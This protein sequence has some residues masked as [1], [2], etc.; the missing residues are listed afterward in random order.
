MSSA[1]AAFAAGLGNQLMNVAGNA[2]NAE[3][4]M[5]KQKEYY[6]LIGSPKAQMEA[7][8]EAGINPFTAAGNIA[9]M[10]GD[11][12]VGQSLQGAPNVASDVA[13]L[14][15]SNFNKTV[16]ENTESGTNKNNADASLSDSQTT[17]QNL[18]N[19]VDEET[20]QA[21]IRR[22]IADASLGEKNTEYL[23]NIVERQP[24]ML[25]LEIGEIKARTNHYIAD[26]SLID[27]KMQ[28]VDEQ[29]KEIAEHINE[30]KANMRYLI[31]AADLNQALKELNEARKTY[32][33]LINTK[34]EIENERY[35]KYDEA[36][37]FIKKY[38]DIKQEHGIDAAN[39]FL[40]TCGYLIEEF[41]KKE[42][43]GKANADPITREMNTIYDGIIQMSNV[44]DDLIQ[45]K[46][47]AQ[48]W[49]NENMNDLSSPAK[50]N[51][52]EL[53]KS[54]IEEINK[55]E[56]EIENEQSN[57]TK[58]KRN[59]GIEKSWAQK[60]TEWTSIAKDLG[61]LLIGIGSIKGAFTPISTP[62]PTTETKTMTNSKGEVIGTTTTTKEY[63]TP[64]TNSTQKTPVTRDT[65][66][67]FDPS[68]FGAFG[69]TP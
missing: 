55:L 62:Q 47:E 44:L 31:S 63:G 69:G 34:Q 64:Q 4:A 52:L 46:E 22:R 16:K 39:R 37:W 3:I 53:V 30:M 38:E 13:D 67:I 36:P 33:D 48:K 5:Q 43:L 10:A 68:T 12:P 1:A 50:K 65:H 7:M 6:A 41:N 8:Q 21:Q 45:Q 40:E 60:V 27:K 58:L 56:T 29:I 19:T 32:Q 14:M 20:I 28:M 24:E 15:N 2:W 9:G 42:A 54:V 18:A 49:L 23:S 61:T 25:E 17:G 57:W 66:P 59:K 51:K 11:S 35:K 26:S